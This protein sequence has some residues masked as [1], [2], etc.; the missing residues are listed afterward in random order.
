MVGAIVGDIVGSIRENFR[1]KS[2]DFPLFTRLTTYTDDTV[3]TV[4]VANA[5]LTGEPYGRAI[6]SHA[7]RHPLRGFGPRFSLWMLSP[8]SRPYNSLAQ[9]PQLWPESG[10]F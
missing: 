6:K 10:C 2:K 1:T 4:A 5:I 8:I 3:L 7:R 9:L